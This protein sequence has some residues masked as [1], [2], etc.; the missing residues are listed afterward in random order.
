MVDIMNYHRKMVKNGK[1]TGMAKIDL[2][3]KEVNKRTKDIDIKVA[4]Y[5][6]P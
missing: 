6:K 2:W 4:R 5:Q 3:G 1:I